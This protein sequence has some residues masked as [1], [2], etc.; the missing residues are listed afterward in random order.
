MF[1]SGFNDMF[2]LRIL[3][4]CGGHGRVVAD[5][6]REANVAVDL[7]LDSQPSC[8]ELEGIPVLSAGDFDWETLGRFQ[9]LVA[10]GDNEVRA[11]VYQ[12]LLNREGIPRSFIHPGAFVSKG[13]FIGPGSVIMAGV[14]VNTGARIGQNSILNTGCSVDHDC[15]V[16]DNAHVCPGCHLAGS[17]Q[18]GAGTLL[19]IGT[20]VIPG[21]RIG[22]QCVVGAGSVVVRDLPDFAVVYGN[23][24]R[25]QPRSPQG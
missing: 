14:V 22:R 15:V 16:G 18:I 8:T 10:I 23:P 19:G 25:I 9:F 13:A 11:R 21:I 3:F 17:V 1:D 12:E 2:G 20:S 4:G 7:I 5:V 24:A 6:A